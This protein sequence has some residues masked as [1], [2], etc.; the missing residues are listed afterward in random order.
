MQ[1]TWTEHEDQRRSTVVVLDLRV[2]IGE[3][4][5]FIVASSSVFALD[6]LINGSLQWGPVRELAL[7]GVM[8]AGYGVL[9]AYSRGLDLTEWLD[10][11]EDFLLTICYP[12]ANPPALA[13][14]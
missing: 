13:C 1:R 8:T 3:K 14:C 5:V 11:V 4:G 12:H 2:G 6:C 7:R 10:T 9:P